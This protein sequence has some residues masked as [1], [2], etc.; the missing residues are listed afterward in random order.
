MT[1]LVLTV[2]ETLRYR[3]KLGQWAWVLHRISGLGTLVFVILHVIDTSWATFYPDLYAKAIAVYQTPLYT[4]GEFILVACIVYH[5]LN[6]FRIA[7]F[8]W[9]PRLWRRQA[10]AVRLVLLGTVVI[11]VP[12][13]VLMFG[14]VVRHYQETGRTFDLG[15]AEVVEGQIPF[16]VGTVVVLA[17]AFA[18]SVV[19]GLILPRSLTGATKDAKTGKKVWKKSRREMMIWQFMRISGVLIIPLVFGHLALIHVVQG[20]F[21]ITTAGFVPVGTNLG[22]NVTGDAATFVALRWNTMIAGVFI[23]RLY[24]VLLLLL[25]AFHG[26]N[27]LDYVIKD[28]VHNRLIQRTF[29]IAAFCTMIGL[30]IVGSLAIINTIPSSTAKLLDQQDQQTSQVQPQPVQEGTH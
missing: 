13:F 25:I 28:Y 8:D 15:L 14:H 17:A 19:A 30:M 4:V 3:G 9:R 11:L 12:T 27:G 26:F 22:P 2:T 23:W 29:R 7:L 20:V 24:D 16:A 10:D 5:A 6:G 1:S 21:D 18:V